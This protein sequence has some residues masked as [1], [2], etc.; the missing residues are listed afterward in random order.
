MWKFIKNRFFIHIH[1]N[2]TTSRPIRPRRHQPDGQTR[3][4]PF[5]TGQPLISQTDPKLIDWFER[6]PLNT[7]VPPVTLNAQNLTNV[8]NLTILLHLFFHRSKDKFKP[9]RLMQ[10]SSGYGSDHL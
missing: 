1:H 9:E 6:E 5:V 3:P 4:T 8:F 10:M 2:V 7:R